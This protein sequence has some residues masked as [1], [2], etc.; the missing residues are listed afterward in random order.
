MTHV[1][2]FPTSKGKKKKKKRNLSTQAT[3]TV[4][5][6][7]LGE[8]SQGQAQLR[9]SNTGQ[10]V[11]KEGWQGSHPPRRMGAVGEVGVVGCGVPLQG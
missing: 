5:G 7:M 8:K 10:A 11:P 3:T 2:N 4:L 9:G 6:P 1:G